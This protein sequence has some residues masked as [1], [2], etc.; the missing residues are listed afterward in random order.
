MRNFFSS[1]R[2]KDSAETAEIRDDP[3]AETA[4]AR[5]A[6]AL[7]VESLVAALRDTARAVVASDGV[8]IVRREGDE[9]LYVT[10]DAVSPLW[11]GQR[12]PIANCVSGMAIR[13]RATIAIPDILTDYRIPQNAY[14]ATFVR[15]MVIAPVGLADPMMAI[16]AY[17]QAVDAVTPVAIDRLNWLASL[18]ADAIVRIHGLPE[19]GRQVA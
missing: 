8:T 13:A 12:F 1:R 9:I 6:A 16:G 2:S 19:P 10:E 5:I 17:W 18:A 15:S 4:H 3:P 7:D 11:T 14:L